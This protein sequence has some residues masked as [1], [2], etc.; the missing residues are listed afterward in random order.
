MILLLLEFDLTRVGKNEYQHMYIFLTYHHR[1][2]RKLQCRIHDV[3]AMNAF[4]H[5]YVEFVKSN[6]SLFY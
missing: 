6:A 4:G 2:E 5:E 1:K 3:M